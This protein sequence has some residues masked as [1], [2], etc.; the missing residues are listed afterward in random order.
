MRNEKCGMSWP[1]DMSGRD[2][3]LEVPGISEFQISNF[4]FRIS[5]VTRKGYDMHIESG[6]AYPAFHPDDRPH[7]GRSI[8]NSLRD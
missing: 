1:K 3:K 4:T 8:W 2:S 5:R 6:Q 7:P